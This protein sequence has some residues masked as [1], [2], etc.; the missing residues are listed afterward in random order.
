MAQLLSDKYKKA[1]DDFTATKPGEWQSQY[2][3]QIR[4]AQNALENRTF[5]YDPTKDAAYQDYAKQYQGEAE[6]ARANAQ[7][8]SA[9]RTGGYGSSYATTAGTEAYGNVMSGLDN[10]IDSLHSQALSTYNN[11]TSE[12]QGN[13]TR[14]QQADQQDYDRYMQA[15]SDWNTQQGSLQAKYNTQLA[16]ERN[17]KALRQQRWAGGLSAAAAIATPIITK[18]LP[19]AM[20][21]L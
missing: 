7:A 2:S 21:M 20:A 16:N 3:G 17:D 13:L 11:E 1:L 6:R 10:V 15:L 4:Q 8:R 12:M 9:A 14:L 19:Y 18:L 5:N